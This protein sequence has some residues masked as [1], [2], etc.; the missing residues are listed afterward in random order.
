MKEEEYLKQNIH[1][2]L[3]PMNNALFLEKLKQPVIY[4]HYLILCD[5]YR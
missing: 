3:Q 4:I 5:V 1:G 2:T